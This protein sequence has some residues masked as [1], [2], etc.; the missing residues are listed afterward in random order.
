MFVEIW[1]IWQIYL[2]KYIFPQPHSYYPFT[3]TLVSKGSFQLSPP[4]SLLSDKTKYN[5]LYNLESFLPASCLNWVVKE[6]RVE[7]CYNMLY[8]N[9]L[10]LTIRVLM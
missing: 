2:R 6:H 9:L 1:Q 3:P 4:T 7:I 5:P 10:L 8:K